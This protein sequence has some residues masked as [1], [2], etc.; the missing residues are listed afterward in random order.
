VRRFLDTNVL[1]YADDRRAGEKRETAQRILVDALSSGEGVI[2]TQVLKEYFSVATRK[3]GLDPAVARHKVELLA[4]LDLIQ[5]DLALILAAIDLSRLHGFSFW[6]GLI[7]RAATAAGCK[8]LLTEDL[9]DGRLV[10]GVRV[11]NPFR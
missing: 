9:Q 11:E 6:D 1:L 3:L 4:T 10:D 7:V 8:V 2:S 5:V